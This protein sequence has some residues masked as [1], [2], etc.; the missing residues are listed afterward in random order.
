MLVTTVGQLVVN[1]VLPP[2]L[3]NYDRVIDKNELTKMMRFLAVKYPDKYVEITKKL[4]DISK[5]AGT[6]AG[7]TTFG[8]AHL[9]KAK[10]S[11]KYFEEIRNQLKNV[12][13]DPNI[14]NKTRQ[15]LITDTLKNY[16]D[17]LEK[18]VFEESLQEENPLALQVATGARG[19][20]ANLASLRA[21]DLMYSD[22]EDKPIPIPIFRSYAEGLSPIEYWAGTY[23]A[24]KGV[25]A[26]KLAT[27]D[28]GFLSKQLNQIMHRLVVT[29][30]DEPSDNNQNTNSRPIRGYPVDTDDPDN[31]GA[32]LAV[33]IGPYKRNTVI[34]PKVVSTLKNLGIKRILVR[35]PIVSSNPDDGLY[36]YDVG[37]R[38]RL[39]LPGRG[40][41]VGLTAAQAISEPISQGQLNV[42]HSGGIA[43]KEKTFS[44]FQ[45]INQLIQGARSFHQSATHSDVDG[46]VTK[47]E[48]APAGGH[49]VYVNQQRFYVKPDQKVTV[50]E[51]DEIEAGDVLSD[52][53]P[54]P[55]IIVQHKGIGEGRKYFIDVFRKTAEA[56]S[57]K[58]NRRN[59][60]LLARGLINFVE[61]DEE[62][63]DYV[64]GDIVK[65]SEIESNYEPRPD[66]KKVDLK[67]AKNKFLETPVLHYTIGTQ[68]KPSVIK[69]L[70]EFGINEVYVHDKPPPFKPTFVRGMTA[71]QND[72]DWMTRMY[73]SGLK[74]G[75]LEA[76]YRG[77]S[78]DE[79]S[80]S[81]VPGLA[82][83]KDFGSIGKI[84]KPEPTIP[85]KEYAEE[86]VKLSSLLNFFKSA[87]QPGGS[88]NNQNQY[89]PHLHSFAPG[90][91][92]VVSPPAGTPP[93]NLYLQNNNANNQSNTTVLGNANAG[94]PRPNLGAVG[95]GSQSGSSGYTN[96]Y[97]NVLNQQQRQQQL[98]RGQPY[99]EQHYKFLTS[100]LQNAK[101]LSSTA[102]D[103]MYG[104][105]NESIAYSPAFYY[106]M[107]RRTGN[108]QAAEFFEQILRNLNVQL[109]MG[110]FGSMGLG[111]ELPPP[112]S[113]PFNSSGANTA[114]REGGGV[115]GNQPNNNGSSWHDY[116][117]GTALAIGLGLPFVNRAIQWWRNIRGVSPPANVVSPGANEVSSVKG[118]AAETP[119]RSGRGAITLTSETTVRPSGGTTA[120][121]SGTTVRPP[122]GGTT[123]VVSS[124]TPVTPSGGAS[125]V[126]SSGT[127]VTPSG[128]TTALTSGTTVRPPVGGAATVVPAGT[129]VT[130]SGGTTALTSGTTVRPPV[131]GAATVVPA[132]TPV[133]PSG[134]VITLTSGTPVTPSGGAS[135]VVS[136]GTPVTPSRG[137]ITLTSESV[138]TE[139]IRP[140][141]GEGRTPSGQRPGLVR[142]LTGIGAGFLL[143]LYRRYL[144][145][146]M[147]E[148]LANDPRLRNPNLTQEELRRQNYENFLRQQN[149]SPILEFIKTVSD[150]V[151]TGAG[152]ASFVPV[153]NAIATPIYVGSSAV[154]TG[155][156]VIDLGVEAFTYDYIQQ[157]MK[158]YEPI[159]EQFRIAPLMMN[160]NARQVPYID[161]KI[162]SLI[163]LLSNV[164]GSYVFL[165]DLKDKE[166]ARYP[167]IVID[168]RKVEEF[169]QSNPEKAKEMD[170]ERKFKDLEN[171]VNNAANQA[172]ISIGFGGY[173]EGPKPPRGRLSLLLGNEIYRLGARPTERVVIVPSID[174]VNDLIWSTDMKPTKALPFEVPVNSMGDP[175]MMLS[176]DSKKKGRWVI[177]P[178][179]R[180]VDDSYLSE[181]V[182]DMSKPMAL[183]NSPPLPNW[184]ATTNEKPLLTFDE[185][186][187]KKPIDYRNIQFGKGEE[188]SPQAIINIYGTLDA[189]VR[190]INYDAIA[191]KLVNSE[192]FTA[193]QL[194]T[195]YILD[196]G[197]LADTRQAEE[198]T[199]CFGLAIGEVFTIDRSSREGEKHVLHPRIRS[200]IENKYHQDKMRSL[201]LNPENFVHVLGYLRALIETTGSGGIYPNSP[202]LYYYLTGVPKQYQ[203][204]HHYGFV[205]NMAHGLMLA[206]IM[207]KLDM[208]R[209]SY[210]Q[211]SRQLANTPGNR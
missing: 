201:N 160:E 175:F 26:T 179:P 82:R 3:R 140:G 11:Q 136:S 143:D 87:Q 6:E 17:K 207:P 24:R 21:S 63:G 75:L 148:T 34:T 166:R 100:T 77:R 120:L 180:S 123:T 170:L 99:N 159:R 139:N 126:V 178:T 71:L 118:Q 45:Y 2:E 141:D 73:G 137:V 57:V 204:E 37:V 88:S 9:Q 78:S 55:S 68:L 74:S 85:V 131:G 163:S 52:G 69:T 168:K 121:T 44:G 211:K 152:I 84:K 156:R 70:Q 31:I 81:F 10:A 151:T 182:R 15:K 79:T 90:Q 145:S 28:A 200:L 103:S 47:I 101:I 206:E 14:D 94:G 183:I 209:G 48:P 32:C 199:K 36:A 83:A 142:T 133:T 184:G 53:L 197:L 127:P 185:F 149:R 80:T 30:I 202:Q 111:E 58:A 186:M 12:L 33:P 16:A 27:Q 104:F 46:V 105:Q 198:L 176:E 181:R 72:P 171:E 109:P 113:S 102:P 203:K 169:I 60:E 195:S 192:R 93:N 134:G 208:I 39:G 54:N 20:A 40:E 187:A 157:M 138:G 51:G 193:D 162:N 61:L 153:L 49:Y 35:S 125:T 89:S 122:V 124:G 106:E 110:Y 29:D 18:S 108:T 4:G 147:D 189:N 188:P 135:T 91:V 50:K 132:G 65:Y 96:P 150:Y 116:A 130:P 196:K 41:L 191:Q 7:G 117:V 174:E 95:S 19:K 25:V 43:G 172:R 167:V 8:L 114:F 107:A 119:V 64:P 128:G 194:K 23:G 164:P 97:S 154:G 158:A 38:E 190:M 112:P 92:N 177:I 98:Q 42:K 76:V 59:I 1:E 115:G 155:A 173:L 66:A 22:S 67:S 165:T 210:I 129:P 62:I 86:L 13:N 146:K 205:E 5:E 56:S 144:N 161:R